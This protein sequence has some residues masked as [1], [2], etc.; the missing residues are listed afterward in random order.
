M[1]EASFY[2]C[3]GSPETSVLSSDPLG[4]CG[5][6]AGRV[7]VM[8]VDG[9][10]QQLVADA[11]RVGYEDLPPAAVTM[12][13]QSLLDA[14]GV[15]VA[16]ADSDVARVL[17][18]GLASQMS[19]TTVVW[20]TGETTDPLTAA[21]VNG[22]AAHA[23][24]FD[25]WSPG[26]GTHP[27]VTIVPSL[28]AAAA[29]KPVSGRAF[30]AA[31]VAAFELQ[32][33]IGVIANPSLYARGFHTTAT[34][35]AFGAAVGATLL[36]GGD[37]RQVRTAVKIA[38][39]EAAGVKSMFGSMGKPLHAGRAASAGLLAAQLALAGFEE[40][41]GDTVFGPQGFVSTHS[42]ASADDFVAAPFGDP[43]TIVGNL[44]KFFPSCF[45]THAAI[46]AA[47]SIRAQPGFDA[48]RIVEV[49][50]TVPPIVVGVCDIADPTS[51]LQGKFSLSYTTAIALLGRDV[52]VSQFADPIPRDAAV[53]RILSVVT[54][55]PDRSFPST[56]T[57]M[58]VLL[59]DGE[60]YSV[61]TDAGRPRWSEDPVEQNALL[62]AKFTDLVAP[63][64]GQDAADE[65]VAFIASLESHS[66]VGSMFDTLLSLNSRWSAVDADRH[67]SVM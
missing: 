66:D 23:L 54:L 40:P 7:G 46:L 28:L 35:G 63:V 42:D 62:V 25:D 47:E 18:R 45:G 31:Y 50:L 24:D 22:T 10:L 37:Q 27:A 11:A 6:S 14:I 39:T 64:L 38:A 1:R 43:W 8:G 61:D 19:G 2:R 67:A 33:R 15:A 9:L 65:I 57:R 3:L 12:V 21:L 26:S 48:D 58:R 53:D 34:I 5:V 29:S 36:L 41:D 13:K 4:S 60:E 59:E 44:F 49:E 30:L 16:G 52:G 20:G 17:R 55:K 32:E 56:G 51:G